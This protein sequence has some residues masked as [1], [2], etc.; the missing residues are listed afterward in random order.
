[1]YTNVILALHHCS[2]EK[3]PIFGCEAQLFFSVCVCQVCGVP[4]V[5]DMSDVAADEDSKG[6]LSTSWLMLVNN[7]GQSW[8]IVLIVLIIMV[9]RLILLTLLLLTTIIVVINTINHHYYYY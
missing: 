7:I 2:R 1:M 8:L 4:R 3:M 9:N 6:A 5:R